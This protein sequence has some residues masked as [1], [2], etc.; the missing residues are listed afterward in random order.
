MVTINDFEI[1]YQKLATAF[2]SEVAPPHYN[3]D[4]SHNATVMRFML[5]ESSTINMYC[6]QFSVFR[7]SF[8]KHIKDDNVTENDESD[9]SDYLKRKLSESLIAFLDKD[10]A[11]FNIIFESYDDKYFDDKYFD[12]LICFD[13]FKTSFDNNKIRLYKLDNSLSFKK[14]INHFSYSDSQIVRLE[15]DKKKHSAICTFKDATIYNSAKDSFEK[16]L[17]LAQ[18]VM[19][20]Q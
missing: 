4:R 13:K 15:Q 1:Y 7:E 16:L 11:S 10:D 6:G 3:S 14:Y 8:F 17:S 12:D 20:M 5:N 19:K 18:P 9:I 2:D